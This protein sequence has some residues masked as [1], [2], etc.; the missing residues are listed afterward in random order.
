VAFSWTRS[1]LASTVVLGLAACSGGPSTVP[2]ANANAANAAGAPALHRTKAKLHLRIHI[3]RK[4]KHRRAGKYLSYAT[5]GMTVAIA[6]RTTLNETVGLTVASNPQNCSGTLAG[7]T[8]T[9]T[10]S[11]L[12]P[13]PSS[14]NCYTATIAT[15]DAISCSGSTCTI[16]G[17]AN[18][19]S[20][21]QN[22]GFTLAVGAANTIALTLDGIPTSVVVIPDGSSSLTGTSS[23][24]YSLS[25]CT[26]APQKV[27]V[28]GVDADGN[29]ILGAGAPTVTLTSNDTTHLAVPSPSPSAPN[30]FALTPPATLAAATIPNANTEVTLTATATP[31]TGSGASAVN[32]A[33]NVT[34][35]SDVCGVISNFTISTADGGN[36]LD[37]VVAGPDKNIWF[38]VS[39]G[40]A[41]MTTTGTI[42][43]IYTSGFHENPKELTVGPDGNIWFTE[44]GAVGN[45][46]T[47]GTVTEY[48][49]G[50][51]TTYQLQGITS[52]PDG[53]S[54]LWFTGNTENTVDTISTSGTSLTLF[55]TGISSNA[56]PSGI[57]VGPDDDL[58][59]AEPTNGVAKITTSGSVTEYSNISLGIPA[60]LPGD[61][62]AGPDGAMWFTECFNSAIGRVTVDGGNASSYSIPSGNYSAQIIAGPDGALWFTEPIFSPGAVAIGRITTAGSVTEYSTGITSN[63][64]ITGI[65]TGPDGAIWFVDGSNHQID[66]MQ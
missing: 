30:R 54:S 45:S 14:A 52:G 31:A 7:T 60:A 1:L 40:L 12:E 9:L 24:G 61:I 65:A 62:V 46:T 32:A 58:W 51:S 4:R 17:S 25:K 33:V 57:A 16:P 63:A 3:P 50:L 2:L 26:I 39:F 56:R 55:S 59:F 38:G 27:S 10:I 44:A 47:A 23:A 48:S 64:L 6:G 36:D 21:N 13:C 34:F 29:Y 37:D 53:A 42:D 20:A 28:I 43:N 49:S 35:N 5:Q 66:R 18:E 22:V 8:C 11:G 15:Y 19:L 41:K